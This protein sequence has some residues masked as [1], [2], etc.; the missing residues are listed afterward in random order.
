MTRD[1]GNY[2]LVI[3]RRAAVFMY[4][5]WRGS[6]NADWCVHVLEPQ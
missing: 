6:T 1:R 5:I 2:R 4:N 3:S